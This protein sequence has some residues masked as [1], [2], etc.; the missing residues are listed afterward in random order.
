M[1]GRSI[2]SSL[3]GAV[4][5]GI[6]IRIIVAGRSDVILAKK[7][8]RWYYDWLLRNGIELYEYQKNILH[9]KLA[10]ADDQW[11]TLGSYNINDLSAHASIELNLD[12]EDPVFAKNTR[13]ILDKIMREDCILI[14]KEEYKRSK[15][16][17]K[18][19]LNWISYETFRVGLFIFTFYFKQRD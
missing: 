8:E 2:R 13:E 1:P 14:S 18:Q 4:R 16:I 19:L 7:A 3:R 12:V 10:I 11:I 6:H 9:G 15:N 5:R 17:F